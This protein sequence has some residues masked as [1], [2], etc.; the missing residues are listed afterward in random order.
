M[1]NQWYVSIHLK[2]IIK[3][4]EYQ[5]I[6]TFNGINFADPDGLAP[7]EYVDPNTHQIVLAD[8]TFTDPGPSLPIDQ[9]NAFGSS[10]GTFL[11]VPMPELDDINH[12]RIYRIGFTVPVQDGPPPS[13]PSTSYLQKHVDQNGFPELSSD[14]SVNSSPI[15]ISRVVWST[16]FRTHA[17][18]SDTFFKRVDDQRG[19]MCGVVMLIGDS[20]HMYVQFTSPPR[21]VVNTHLL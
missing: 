4:S 2:P 6:R 13:H 12:Q 9:I 11:C 7:S 16:R 20:A 3:H 14:P 1:Q 10:E 19:N 15:S 8:V 5:Q 17:A 18:I 21:L